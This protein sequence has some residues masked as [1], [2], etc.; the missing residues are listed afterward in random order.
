[1]RPYKAVQKLKI[2]YGELH[3]AMKNLGFQ[4][5]TGKSN[6][7]V[8]EQ[9]L[10]K[11][12]Y[13]ILYFNETHKRFYPVILSEDEAMVDPYDLYHISRQL[14]DFGYIENQDDLIEM[15]EKNRIAERQ[16]VPV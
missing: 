9:L 10:G 5:R 4:Q 13:F 3:K 7:E 8:K 14:S 2:T 12:R 16:A 6:D 15:I 11:P 1:M